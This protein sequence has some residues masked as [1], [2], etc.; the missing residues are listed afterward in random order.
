MIG[1]RSS[2]LALISL[3]SEAK[4]PPPSK[5]PVNVLVKKA[6]E[7]GSTMTYVSFIL[8]SCVLK[9]GMLIVKTLFYFMEPADYTLTF[10][11]FYFLGV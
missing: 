5:C 6:D 4:K 10:N 2:T 9:C 1:L 3:P 7:N 11:F 8:K